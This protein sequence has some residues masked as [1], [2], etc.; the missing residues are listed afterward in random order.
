MVVCSKHFY[1]AWKK[2][3]TAHVSDVTKRRRLAW[4]AA[5][6]RPNVTFKH[7]P[8]SMVVCSKHFYKGMQSFQPPLLTGLTAYADGQDYDKKNQQGMQ[9]ILPAQTS[10]ISGHVTEM[11]NVAPSDD[12][13][14]L[15]EME[16]TTSDEAAQICQADDA[17]EDNAQ[18]RQNYSKCHCRLK[19]FLLFQE[20][21][22]KLKGELS[23]NTLD[24]NFLKDNHS[25]VKYY[26]GLPSF[27]LMALLM[28]FLP[29]LTK[30]EKKIPISNS[31]FN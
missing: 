9:V 20:E 13:T 18:E 15:A 28:Q 27:S 31:P 17:P 10:K 11:D 1:K 21:N 30:T 23:R 6:R 26:T 12:T 29:S 2:N 5:V 25:K 16:E 7:A 22:R 14:P 3:S 19:E 8:V 24:D 4:I